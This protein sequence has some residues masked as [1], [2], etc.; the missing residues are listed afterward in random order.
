M[1][2]NRPNLIKFINP[3][4]EQEIHSVKYENANFV[5]K[6]GLFSKD[7]HISWTSGFNP[8]YVLTDPSSCRIISIGGLGDPGSDLGVV[9][10]YQTSGEKVT[11]NLKDSIEGLESLSREYGMFSNFPWLTAIDLD[12]KE[13]RFWVCDKVLATLNLSDFVV[14]IDRKAD[15]P[16]WA[17]EKSESKI[18]GVNF[19]D[20]AKKNLWKQINVD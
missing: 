3:T 9:E 12:S 20:A 5:K 13:M 7:E 18:M 2:P 10:I 15:R 17:F 14:S 6:N 1:Q 4:K 19:S 11:I 16:E 8:K